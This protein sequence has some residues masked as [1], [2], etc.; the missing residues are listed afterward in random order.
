MTNHLMPGARVQILDFVVSARGPVGTWRSGY[1]LVKLDPVREIAR[2]RVERTGFGQGMTLPISL[3]Q[4]RV[5]Q[6]ER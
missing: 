6:S 4:V 1:V 3:S 5:D 2:V